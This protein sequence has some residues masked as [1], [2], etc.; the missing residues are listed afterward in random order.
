MAVECSGLTIVAARLSLVPLVSRRYLA[1]RGIVYYSGVLLNLADTATGG[2]SARQGI[3]LRASRFARHEVSPVVAWD[4]GLFAAG[5][6]ISISYVLVDPNASSSDRNER[7]SS[8]SVDAGMSLTI[9]PQAVE[10][11]SLL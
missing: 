7:P 8:P 10:A 3:I 2:L 5:Q 4:A 9:A 6:D 1:V 11:F